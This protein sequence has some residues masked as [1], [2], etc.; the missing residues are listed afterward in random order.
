MIVIRN[1]SDIFMHTGDI[2]CTFGLFLPEV[3][4][5]G[6]PKQEDRQTGQ[7]T[8]RFFIDRPFV[9]LHYTDSQFIKEFPALILHFCL[10]LIVLNR[11]LKIFFTGP[12]LPSI[13]CRPAQQNR[14]HLYTNIANIMTLIVH[15]T[16]TIYSFG[17]E[18]HP[19]CESIPLVGMYRKL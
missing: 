19:S 7:L 17:L 9:C 13:Y 8:D 15:L 1:E 6:L 4:T 14:F 16:Q 18:K 2:P 5:Q 12:V 11:F 10:H 3:H